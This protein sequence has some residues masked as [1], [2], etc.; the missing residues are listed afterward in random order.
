M[1]VAE[2]ESVLPSG[3]IAAYRAARYQVGQAPAFVLA[4][5][6]FS[7]ELAAWMRERACAHAAFITAWNPL[8]VELSRAQNQARQRRLIDELRGRGL[9]WIE[10]HGAD[11]LAGWSDEESLLVLGADRAT[12]CDLGRRHE[13]NAVLWMAADA[14][15]RLLLLR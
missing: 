5:D 11:P 4:V 8:G 15:P 7:P 12:A 9:S 3:L 13:Q 10:G 1:N 6:V 2:H 14:I